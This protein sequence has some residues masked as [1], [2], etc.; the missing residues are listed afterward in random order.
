M[1]ICIYN[2]NSRNSRVSRWSPNTAQMQ[3]PRTQPS[4]VTR[5]YKTYGRE[6]EEKKNA[7]RNTKK[8]KATLPRY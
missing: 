1:Y 8:G 6:T 2:T 7:Q 4:T 3:I 5:G